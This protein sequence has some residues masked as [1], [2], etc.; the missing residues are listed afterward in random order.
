MHMHIHCEYH[1]CYIYLYLSLFIF[2]IDINECADEKTNMCEYQCQDE[3]I[4]YTC[5]CDEGFELAEDGY[6]CEGE[7]V[8]LH[9]IIRRIDIVCK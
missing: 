7:L 3:D 4:G 2:F 6:T 8:E 1:I 9:A 5:L